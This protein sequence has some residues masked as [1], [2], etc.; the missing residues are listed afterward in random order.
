MIDT[1]RDGFLQ[2]CQYVVVLLALLIFSNSL[3]NLIAKISDFNRLSWAVYIIR[4][5]IWIFLTVSLLTEKSKWMIILYSVW[6]ASSC[7]LVSALNFET[8][9]RASNSNFDMV[10]IVHF[11]VVFCAFQNHFCF[12]PKHASDISLSEPPLA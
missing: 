5:L 4:R 11:L 12:V 2:L 6:W 7:M 8:V 10:Q 3:W 9:Q 1:E